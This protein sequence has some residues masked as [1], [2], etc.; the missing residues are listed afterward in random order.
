MLTTPASLP[1][2]AVAYFFVEAGLSSQL[3]L[4][5][6]T[7]TYKGD[8]VTETSDYVMAM[9]NDISTAYSFASDVVGFTMQI[10]QNAKASENA[11][12]CDVTIGFA[13]D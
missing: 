10:Y 11:V 8:P 5:L 12:H 9:S 3:D 2:G 13:S 4:V 6:G 1:L 7:C